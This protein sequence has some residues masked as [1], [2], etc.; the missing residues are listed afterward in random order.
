MTEP[1][2]GA[3]DQAVRLAELTAST[4]DRAKEHPLR[5][6]VRSLG[7]LLGRV[8][9]EQAGA[10]VFENV[11][12]LRRLLIQSRINS[13]AAPGEQDQDKED[14]QMDQARSIVDRL[15]VKEAYWITKAFATYFELTNLAETNHRKRRRRAGKVT[16]AQADQPGS[17]RGTLVR[18]RSAGM[19]AEQALEA[20][21]QV[22]VLPVF[23]AHPT[24]VARRTVL[25]KRRRISRSLEHLDRLP[26][27]AADALPLED[28]IP[29]QISAVW[30]ATSG[31][32]CTPDK[33]SWSRCKSR[34]K[35]TNAAGTARAQPARP[36]GIPATDV[37]RRFRGFVIL[38]L[39]QSAATGDRAYASASEFERDLRI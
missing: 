15:S 3:K 7:I 20:L 28:A 9:V 14:K 12:Q 5:R 31:A 38:R 33:M 16:P 22:K 10:P 13:S 30:L 6:D 18:M 1:L 4:G 24:E 26:L 29:V 11:E 36:A 37:C 17:F 2:W 35:T 23:T 25:Q 21:R 39:R 8:L 32:M 19:T 34:N 27:P